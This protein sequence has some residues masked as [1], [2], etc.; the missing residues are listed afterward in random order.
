MKVSL[1]VVFVILL[2]E[3]YKLNKKTEQS[4]CS[5]HVIVT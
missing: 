4:Y 1:F 3:Y 5:N 2:L